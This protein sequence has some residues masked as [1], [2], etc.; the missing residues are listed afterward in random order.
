MKKHEKHYYSSLKTKNNESFL[1]KEY[2]THNKNK[3]KI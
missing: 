3:T 1:E 2:K